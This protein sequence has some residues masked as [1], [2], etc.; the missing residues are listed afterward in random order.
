MPV[1]SRNQAICI[2]YSEQFA[3]ETVENL[4]EK[5]ESYGDLDICFTND[6]WKPLL[7]TKT[8]INGNPSYYQRYPDMEPEPSNSVDNVM[9]NNYRQ[10]TDY[11]NR[12][13]RPFVPPA[14]ELFDE[15][16]MSL[17]EV[18]HEMLLVTNFFD[19]KSAQSFASWCGLSK[20]DFMKASIQRKFQKNAQGKTRYRVLW[21]LKEN[22]RKDIVKQVVSVKEKHKA[23]IEDLKNDGY[24][25]VGY[26]R[27]SRGDE[28]EG[29][30]LRLLDS[31]IDRLVT[32]SSVDMV[33]ASYSCASNEPFANRDHSHT[34]RVPRTA[35]NT[36]DLLQ[37]IATSTKPVAIAVIDFAG[38]STNTTDITALINDHECI[39]AIV[40]DNLESCN[41]AMIFTREELLDPN[42]I[43]L[44]ASRR[45]PIQRSKR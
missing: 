39:Q 26:V 28:D 36:Q 14:C 20:L 3:K 1:I 30:R 23:S 24:Q 45:A 5:L 18:Y 16:P 19:D 35:G 41:S 44:F 27:K 38:L 22:H 29:T 2:F 6:P 13:Y 15:K 31:M 9:L 21:V 32:D 33:Y 7:Q 11:M 43:Q 37:F 40:V 12:V 8:K 10:V 34:I 42:T 17:K 4:S 25:V